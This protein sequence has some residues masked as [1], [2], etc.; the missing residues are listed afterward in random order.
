MFN[1]EVGKDFP[2]CPDERTSE[3][4][5]QAE[6]AVKVLVVDAVLG[7][8]FALVH[9]ASQPGFVIDAAASTQDAADHLARTEYALVIVD[10][11]LGERSGLAFLES[12]RDEHPSAARALVTANS[13]FEWRRHAIERAELAFLLTKPWS[14]GALRRTLRAL[15][16]TGAESGAWEQI[17]GPATSPGARGFS[18]GAMHAAEAHRESLLCT[19][20]AGLNS[21]EREGEVFELLHSELAESFGVVRWIWVDEERRLGS[22]IAGEERLEE[23]VDPHTLPEADLRALE[24]ARRSSGVSRLDT[25]LAGP[26]GS[27]A[28]PSFG[29]AL[30]IG[31]RR[32]LTGVVW[33]DGPRGSGLASLLGELSGGLQL[34][35]Q[36]I[37][38]A[39]ARSLAARNLARR[40]SEEL[41]TPVGALTHAIDLLRCEAERLGLSAEWVD[42][43]SSESERVVR[44]V[45]HLEGEIL[46]VPFHTTAPGG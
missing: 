6:A 8:R 14:P 37:R 20:L 12:V 33:T 4:S 41:R 2:G 32:A 29:L 5:R 18:Q 7:S 25:T 27:S 3:W 19:L 46:A 15:L 9:A 36:R 22:R 17:D 31:G 40:V 42:R 21:C 26:T 11:R 10:E 24:L 43:I 1:D 23:D 44:A 34:A 28:R 30:R 45:E 35:I 39:E 38:S 16:T 13:D